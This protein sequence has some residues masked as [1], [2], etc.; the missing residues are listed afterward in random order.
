MV[1]YLSQN[2][3]KVQVSMNRRQRLI[4]TLQ[5]GPVDRPAVNFYEIGGLRMDPSDPDPFNVYNH[6]S[7]K[8]LLD[9]AENHTDIIRLR[10]PVREDSH[11]AWGDSGSE[12][13][14]RDEFF[15]IETFEQDRCR[16]TQITV[17]VAGRT[18]TSTTRR[19][20]AVDTVWT[21]EHLL[22]SKEDLEA[23][24]QLPDEAFT[25]N[26]NIT[27]LLEEEKA[28]GDRGIVMVDT[29]DPLCAAATLFSMENYTI[30]AMTAQQLFHQLLEK[31]ARYIHSRTE[32]V[33]K[34]FPGRLWRIYGPEFAT[35]P[36]LPPEFFRQYVV[37][38]TG[39]MVK[40]IQK[41]GGFARIHCHGQIK[42]ALDHIAAMG[43]DA[44]D[45]VEPPSQGDV[46]LSYVRQKYGKELVIFGNLEIA[47][48]ENTDP[49]KF[50]QIVRQSITDGTAGP[51]RGFVLMPSAA[52]YGR[53][54]SP[55]TLRNYEIMIENVCKL[56]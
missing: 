50:E 48:I 2:L 20:Q 1:M 5:G 4:T 55:Q 18:M 16:V 42:N 19:E 11:R 6:P 8:P 31:H 27:P 12:K 44:I 38:Y 52:P 15:K 53:E 3:S 32:Q 24:L 23:Y 46:E 9:L 47:D 37:Q 39:P 45:P 7:W 34:D 22:K 35:E 49:A 54:V 29:E 56:K 40:M 13:G 10:S 26:I 21:T 43:A 25:E 51:G 30:L 41:H 36:Y 17:T 14:I 33:A 28:L